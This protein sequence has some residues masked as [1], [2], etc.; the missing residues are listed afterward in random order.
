[1]RRA[2]RRTLI[3]VLIGFVG[4][5]TLGAGFCASTL[6]V[7]RRVGPPFAGAA[8][9]EISAADRV[10]LRASWSQPAT[11][12]GRCVIVLHGISDSRAAASEF[13]AMFLSEGYAVLAPDSRAHGESGGDFVTYGLLEKHDVI[14]WTHWMRDRR[15]ARIYGLG[16]SLGASILIQASALE[17]AFHAIAAECPYANLGKVGEYRMRK[18]LPLP[19]VLAGVT[20]G[21]IVQAGMLFARFVYGLDFRDVTPLRSI[22]A[23]SA[24]VLLIHG[25]DDVNTPPD[26]SRQLAAIRPQRDRLWLVPGARHVN[27]SRIAPSEFRN[28]VLDWFR[29]H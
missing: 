16:E 18:M 9:V 29:E 23:S 22:A 27:A 13:A 26:E 24:P 21:F 28:R 11:P 25:L 17:P 5:I 8:R 2:A 6:R 19:A 20:A 14:A 15:C 7:P 10:A 4:Y 12:T 3:A 1:M